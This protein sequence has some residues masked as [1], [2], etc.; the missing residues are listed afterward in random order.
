M[1]FTLFLS[2]FVI[3][4]GLGLLVRELLQ[5]KLPMPR[6]LLGIFILLIGIHFLIIQMNRTGQTDTYSV[7]MNNRD[8]YYD[9]DNSNEYVV[10]F[11][12][13]SVNLENLTIDQGSKEIEVNVVFGHADV[14]LPDSIPYII[15]SNIAF[16]GT[17]GNGPNN[18][19]IGDFTSYS[20]TFNSDTTHLTIIANVSF[21]SITWR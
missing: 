16:G 1:S 2:L 18:G 19:G 10:V 17:D 13:A 8:F 21:G 11:G 20:N 6:Y 12:S 7:F 3:F 15:H 4:A 14:V 5:L 9:S